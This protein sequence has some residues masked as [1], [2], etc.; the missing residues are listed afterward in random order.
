[1]NDR[2]VRGAAAEVVSPP[3]WPEVDVSFRYEGE[4]VIAALRGELDVL[5]A[6]A[7]ARILDAGLDG[8]NSVV[9][10]VAGLEF[11]DA[12]GLQVIAKL[13]RRLNDAGGGL[14]VR[15]A[16]VLLV[17]LLELTD[18][19]SLV[20]VCSELPTETPD[21]ESGGAYTR[22]FAAIDSQDIVRALRESI[23]AAGYDAV[24]NAAMQ[25]LAS[26]APVL[27]AA[28][29]TA[30]VTMRRRDRFV[31]VAASDPVAIDLDE[32]QYALGAGPCVEAATRGSAVHAHHDGDTSAWHA[33][34]EEAERAGIQAVL[35]TPLLRDTQPIGALN[36]YS[37]NRD[38]SERQRDG[39]AVLTREV[40][41]I[42]NGEQ[43]NGIQLIER[44]HDA[45]TSRDLIALAQGILMERNNISADEGFTQLRR[46]SDATCTPLREQAES[47][48]NANTTPRRHPGPGAL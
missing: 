23:A 13:A 7:F 19:G 34:R 46:D 11:C 8:Q 35:S 48:V 37:S 12:A 16:S 22:A 31:T 43:P 15:S 9:L 26:I 29:E 1:L 3:A 44:L 25:M 14:D 39:A 4:S 17:K 21:R 6:E 33:V 36:L 18:V 41:T 30:S 45:L 2:S 38:F 32:T 27:I 5:S 24:V 20:T 42:V 40:A 47:I 10:D 28:V